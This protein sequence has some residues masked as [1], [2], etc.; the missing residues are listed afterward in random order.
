MNLSIY[1]TNIQNLC[2]IFN[3]IFNISRDTTF[4]L[5]NGKIKIITVSSNR[6]LV[7]EVFLDSI[8]TDNI[9]A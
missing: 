2:K 6:D 4:I 9:V 8:I 1:L 3:N 5:D 7:I